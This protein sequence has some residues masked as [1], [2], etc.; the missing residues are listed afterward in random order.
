MMADEGFIQ[1]IWKHKLYDG[2]FLYTS[3]GQKMEVLDPGEQNFHGGP[4]FLYSRIRID[5]LIW[6]GNV[7]I[8]RQAS[9]W[10]GHRH[11]LD[12]AYNNVILHV[13]G[14]FNTDVTNSLGRRIFTFVPGYP[15]YLKRRYE[16]LKRSERWLACSDYL[17]LVPRHKV[18]AWLLSLNQDRMDQKCLH[19]Q[20]FLQNDAPDINLALFRALS[21]GFGIPL[22]ALPFELLVK[23]IPLHVLT[24]HRDNVNDLEA[25]F[26]GQSGLLSPAR[27]HG[28]YPYALWNRYQEL[29]NQLGEKPLPFH[30]WKF[31]RL[32]P[33]SFP[34][35]RISQLA[36]L[37][38]LRYPLADSILGCNSIAELEQV[39]RVK[40]S[41]YWTSH[42]LFGKVSSPMPKYPGQQFISTLIINII[43]PFLTTL[44]KQEGR[45]STALAAGEILQNLKAES[46]Q[47]TR[48]WSIF[49][50]KP[51]NARES[52][53][54][55]HLYHQYCK[56]RRCLECRIGTEIV[57]NAIRQET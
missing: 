36:G 51:G 25:I 24:E 49:G 17:K 21:T 4:D 29:K 15:E 18:E 19:M 28:S 3:C 27:I 56:Q 2:R 44:D 26:F 23:R 10:Y 7:E 40:A 55:L 16:I 46:N 33:P 31:L 35:L 42:Y 8:H 41:E 50:I 5:G 12:P 53:A 37:F 32:R 9:E 1:F 11:H 48:N 38:H 14:N 52:Q 13:V 39:F 22:N 43:V 6:V 57:Q 34:T 47:F 30:L 45:T 20:Q 54:L